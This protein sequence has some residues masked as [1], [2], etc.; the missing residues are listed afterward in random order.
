MEYLINVANI[1][2]FS[3]YTVRDILLLRILTVIGA[4]ILILYFY[5]LPQPLM[6]A[7]YWN[8]VFTALNV[9]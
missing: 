1:F 6:T 2:Y 8:L 4:I 3:A 9:Y 7:I 5:Y